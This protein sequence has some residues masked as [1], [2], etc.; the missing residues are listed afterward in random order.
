LV[1]DP[2]TARTPAEE[3]E[4]SRKSIEQVVREHLARQC[5]KF[6]SAA[7][8]ARVLSGTF[9]ERD[10]LLPSIYG[11]RHRATNGRRY[12][13]AFANWGPNG[14]VI[15][16]DSPGWS[17]MLGSSDIDVDVLVDHGPPWLEAR[18]RIR[19]RGG[20][21]VGRVHVH[22]HGGAPPD[23]RALRP[24]DVENLIRRALADRGGGIFIGQDANMLR[25]CFRTPA[26]R[27]LD[28][29]PFAEAI[30]IVGTSQPS[31]EQRGF[32][33]LLRSGSIIADASVVEVKQD[34]PEWWRSQ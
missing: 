19:G 28:G 23:W 22:L 24:A 8:A 3:L 6:G 14:E 26:G 29:A 21:I 10:D 34:G 31:D 25:D 1:E 7:L 4:R 11:V 2:W 32:V 16:S 12:I 30:E 15:W 33:Q 5:P 9:P 27:A 13:G 17:M 18:V 20:P